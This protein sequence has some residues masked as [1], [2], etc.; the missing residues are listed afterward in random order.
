MNPLRDYMEYVVER[1]YGSQVVRSEG[2]EDAFS[3]REILN[4]KMYFER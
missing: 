4:A 2:L 1:D 3:H